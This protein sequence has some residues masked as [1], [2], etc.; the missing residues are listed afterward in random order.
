MT[1]GTV[2]NVSGRNWPHR[3]AAPGVFV[4]DPLLSA[5][6]HMLQNAAPRLCAAGHL[7]SLVA[8]ADEPAGGQWSSV[9]VLVQGYHRRATAGIPRV[10]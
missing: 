10:L 3:K 5:V 8:P 7:A 9:Q 6:A 2:L 4:S 1:T